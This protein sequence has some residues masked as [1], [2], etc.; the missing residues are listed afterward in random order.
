MRIFLSRPSIEKGEIE[1]VTDVLKSGYLSIG[2]KLNE[3]EK[4]FAD[5]I[6]TKYAIAVSSGTAGLHLCI[7]ALNLKPGDEVITTPFS[8][9][10]SANCILFVGAKPVFVDIN[11]KT[12]NIDPD[13]I[14]KAITNKTKA[15]LIVH[16]FG[17]P[18]DMDKIM[19]IAKKYNFPVIEDTCESLGAEY[20]RKKAGTFGLAS[21]FAF[22]P[23]KQITT[24]EGGMVCTNDKRVYELCR[25]LRNQ[26][27]TENKN[28]FVHEKIGYNYRLDEMSCALGIV[29][30]KRIKNILKKREKV[31]ETYNIL[32]KGIEGIETPYEDKC[33]K[34]SWFVYFIKIAKSLNRDRISLFLWKRGIQT[35]PYLQSIHL[36]PIY[37]K[38]YNYKK[39]VLPIS[40]AV[41]DQTLA[42]P[43]YTEMEK[44][45]IETVCSE[46]KNVISR[47]SFKTSI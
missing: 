43:F 5:Y 8:F 42:L 35:K 21:V 31:A 20:K 41:S 13:K 36:Q 12:F 40:E 47:N 6:G 25:S 15:L 16:I 9:I 7:R 27:R 10:S 32:L 18:C 28:W 24:G 4:K 37:K 22:Y 11:P 46:L 44:Q 14:E 2:P 33:A 3:F 19:R 38:L 26:G 45:T 17:L 23:N 1:A 30:L 39:G 29:Q 34:R